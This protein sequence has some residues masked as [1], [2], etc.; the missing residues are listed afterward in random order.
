[1]KI[2]LPIEQIADAINIAKRAIRDQLQISETVHKL[3]TEED[4]RRYAGENGVQER[5]KELE[6]AEY[7]IKA[8]A[9]A[10]QKKIENLRRN[11]IEAIRQQ[12]DPDGTDTKDADFG[13]FAANVIETPEKL[14][15]LLERHDTPAFHIVAERYAAARGWEGFEFFDR[16]TAC[17]AYTEQVFDGLL[18]AA[19]RPT[20]AAAI[21]YTLTE[22]E[23][24]RIAEAYNLSEEFAAS[25]GAKLDDILVR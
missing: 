14:N 9:S 25:G 16:E 23:F 17:I 12:T 7:N 20:G 13:L 8:I 18:T 22:N 1:M 5:R 3:G 24:A 2:L 6:A 4:V 10:A 19:A 21:Q 11:A 15:R